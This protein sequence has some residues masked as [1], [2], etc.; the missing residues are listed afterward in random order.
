MKPIVREMRDSAFKLERTA[1][2]YIQINKG[3]RFVDAE[4]R[5]KAEKL[6]LQFQ[7]EYLSNQEFKRYKLSPRFSWN[8]LK[9]L[10]RTILANL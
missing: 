7:Q 3:R 8:R 6:L 2:S 4:N 5:E 10:S 1:D 9:Y